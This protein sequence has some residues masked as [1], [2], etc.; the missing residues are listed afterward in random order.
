MITAYV[1]GPDGYTLERNTRFSD[2]WGGNRETLSNLLGGVPLNGWTLRQIV[3]STRTYAQA[4]SAVSRARFCS[5]EYSVMSGV[6]RGTVL[7][8]DPDR[9]VHVQTLGAPG[10]GEARADYVIMTN[11][12]FFFGD[13]REHFDPTA[14]GGGLGRPSRREA[15]EAF[16]AQWSVANCNPLNP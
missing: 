14:G 10:E 4:V 6:G 15:A 13:V 7:S 5:P 8:K 11:F 9:V 1:P 3:Q 12:D 2:H 16:L